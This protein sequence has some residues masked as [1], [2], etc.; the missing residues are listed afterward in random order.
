MSSAPRHTIL[1]AEGIRFSY[2]KGDSLIR[3]LDFTVSE[4][5]AVALLGANGSGKST[6]LKIASGILKP[7]AG[8]VTLWGKPLFAYRNQDRAKLI[9]YL[10]QTLDMTVPFTVRELVA[11]GL[12][13]YEIPPS[14]S[15]DEA[16]DMV[17]LLDKADSLLA[18]LSGGERRR[19]FIA[20][21]LLQGAGLL[22]LDEPLANLDVKY[23][24]E[25]LRLLS[26]LRD[27][28]GISVVMALHD[29]NAALQFGRVIM[30]KEGAVIASGRPEEVLSEANI[31]QAFDI[32]VRLTRQPDGSLY[33]SW[34]GNPTL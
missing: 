11:M 31:R 20:M 27:E 30:V 18:D 10:P 28:R 2:G 12:Y 15:A 3:D 14:L 23:Q 33:I 29:M 6:M 25:L 16:L 26:R 7:L 4:S 24:I 19:T 34:M 32:E 5:E 22:L 1:R 21:T 9:S 17:G 8:T 13:P